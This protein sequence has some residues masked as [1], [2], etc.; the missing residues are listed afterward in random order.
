MTDHA[1]EA[2]A[3]GAGWQKVQTDR[4][5]GRSPRFVTEFMRPVTGGSGS[6]ANSVLGRGESDANQATADA[7]ALLSLNGARRM[8]YGVG[9][10]AGKDGRGTQLTFDQD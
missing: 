3:T 2:A 5:A 10:A 7:N 6:G 8:R 4:G 9:S 1:N